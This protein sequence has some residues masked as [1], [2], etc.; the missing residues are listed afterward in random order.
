MKVLFGRYDI[1]ADILNEAQKENFYCYVARKQSEKKSVA[2]C[3][4]FAPVA[5]GWHCRGD[6]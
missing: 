5:L 1:I 4:D 6:P 2:D 3:F